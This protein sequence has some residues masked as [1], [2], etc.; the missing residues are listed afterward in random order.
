MEAG[1]FSILGLYANHLTVT[2]HPVVETDSPVE[3]KSKLG[4]LLNR[5]VVLM[6]AYSFNFLMILSSSS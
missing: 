2:S 4:W 5:S 6:N 3:L 1:S